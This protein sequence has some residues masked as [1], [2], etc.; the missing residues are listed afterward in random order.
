LNAKNW[1][2]AASIIDGVT[3]IVNQYG[4]IIVLEDDIVT[5][6]YFL[7]FMNDALNFYA[8]NPKVWHIAGWNHPS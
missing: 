1:G 6:P 4:N 7:K 3:N 2:L 5:S 8:N